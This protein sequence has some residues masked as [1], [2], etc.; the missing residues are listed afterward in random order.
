VTPVKPADANGSRPEAD[1]V[2]VP[3]L[4]LPCACSGFLTADPASSGSVHYAVVRHQQ[5]WQHQA[6]REA[7]ERL[8]R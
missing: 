8:A 1:L 5:T 2:Y 7:M 3:T 6:W 4:T